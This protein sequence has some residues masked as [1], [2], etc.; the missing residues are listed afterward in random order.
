MFFK[1]FA[2]GVSDKRVSL[3][4]NLCTCCLNFERILQMFSIADKSGD[5]GA[6][7]FGELK[8]ECFHLTNELI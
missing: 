7:L 2:D 8:K 4:Q 1:L 5:V 6:S 3:A